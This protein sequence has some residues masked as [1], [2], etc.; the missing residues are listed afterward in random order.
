M[1]CPSLPVDEEDDDDEYSSWSSLFQAAL[2]LHFVHLFRG[3][4]C[5]TRRR[6]ILFFF[7]DCTIIVPKSPRHL[8]NDG[9]AT[10]VILSEATEAIV[11]RFFA[12]FPDDKK[13]RKKDRE[14]L[15]VPLLCPALLDASPLFLFSFFFF[16]RSFKFPHTAKI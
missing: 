16:L 10:R 6:V 8:R 12:C 15:C 1:S 11:S 3:R 7:D 4:F 14:T 13:K 5:A 2:H 9:D